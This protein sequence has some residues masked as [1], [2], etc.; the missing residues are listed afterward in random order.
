MLAEFSEGA[1]KGTAPT[2]TIGIRLRVTG[3]QK[4]WLILHEIQIGE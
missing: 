2:G 1:A 4:N 3:P